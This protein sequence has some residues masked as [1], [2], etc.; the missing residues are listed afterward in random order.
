MW[1][2][3]FFSNNGTP[4]TGL[5]PTIRIRDLSDD[6]LAV[7]DG[8]M[9]ESGDGSYK[10]DFTAYDRDEDYS[11]RCDGGA[12]LSDSDRYTFA[13]NENYVDDVVDSTWSAN[14]SAY[15]PGPNVAAAMV[16]LLYGDYI[17]VDATSNWSGTTMFG[18][19][20]KARPI[21]NIGDAVI[22]ANNRMIY[23]LMIHT[24]VTVDADDDIGQKTI[25]TIGTMGI[26]VTLTPGCS[27]DGTMF[28]NLDL[29]GTLSNGD[30]IL[31][32][33]C[34][35]GTFEGFSGIMNVVSLLDG[36]EVSF[37]YWAT[38]IDCVAGGSAGNEPEL[39]MDGSDVSIHKYTGNIKFKGKTGTNTV[40]ADFVGGNIVIDTSCVSGSIQLLGTGVLE[41]DNSGP[42]CNIDTEGFIT[43]DN[44]A[45]GVWEEMVDDHGGDGTTGRKLKDL[46]S[47]VILT[48]I[49]AGSGV[50]NNQIEFPAA[51][52]STDGAYDPA[53]VAIVGGT[54]A[55]QTRGIYQYD[56][57]SRTATVDRNWKELPDITSEFIITAWPG[58]EHVN[59]GL[60]QGGTAD[61]ITLNTLASSAD[62]VYDG[63]TI[64]LRS[65]T[66]EDQIATVITYDGLA[67]VAT[68]SPNWQVIPDT[69]T[70]YVMLPIRY[71]TAQQTADSVWDENLAD[72]TEA[73]TY[74][75]ELATKADLF[76]S[77][78]TTFTL[79]VTGY[80]IDGDND[81]GSWTDVFGRDEIYWVI[82]EDVTDG[83]KVE[84]RF[85]LPSEEHRAGV[86]RVFGRYIGTP[87]GT[88]FMT[89]WIWN[90]ETDAFEG[91]IIEFMPGGN[92][93]DAEY[94][95]EYFERNIDRTNNNEVRIRLRHNITAP[96]GA[97]HALYL[98]F[99]EVTSI[100]PVT[101][102]DI[103]DAVWDEDTSDH[104]IPTSFGALSQR[105]A[106]MVHENVWIDRPVYDGS[107]NLISARV[108]I[109]SDGAS[110][111]TVNDVI[112]T[113]EV[114]APG[115]GP[116]RFV[117][118]SQVKV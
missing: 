83:L 60:A 67:Q 4:A 34:S 20:T 74:G 8:S 81:S 96:Y 117:T 109:Y 47:T 3:T 7:T 73:G 51:A 95:H 46:A 66:G 85:N 86:F 76:A 61:T 2:V 90:Y 115:D 82:G 25:E 68:I 5:S 110:V 22:V 100:R 23:K 88:H 116:G 118:W 70:G 39:T 87:A 52:S 21:N 54:G 26:N 31:V 92:T 48:G 40:V 15:V 111:G 107:A 6:S 43:V 62:N 19:G 97:A 24:D 69:T 32:N 59:E 35:V 16:N 1:I 106:G 77:A 99:V 41:A 44:I 56:G 50:G 65:G 80:I 14:L 98:D 58:R 36:A 45:Y 42:N 84:F 49:V 91:L 113:Y 55:G 103:A 101:A 71:L 79:P 78:E 38:L 12:G 102:E 112:G 64:F 63:Q 75:H 93:S 89:L 30:V 18:I 11:I 27:A 28:R 17:H 105:I 57:F 37:G 13:G 108:R 53:L 94:T 104:M 114:T 72:H 9:L 10:Y 33:D 29:S